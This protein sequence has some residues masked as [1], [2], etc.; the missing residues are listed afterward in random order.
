VARRSRGFTLIEL[1]VVIAIIA[2][3]IGLL[4]PALGKARNAA[5]LAISM[6]NNRQILVGS[7]QYRTA[8]KDRVPMR[9]TNYAN[10][11]IQGG[12]D[13]WHYGGK[14]P[15]TP[16]AT[17]DEPAHSRPLNE[18]LYSDVVFEKPAGYVNTGSGSTWNFNPGSV[19]ANSNDRNI[20][21]DAF[22]SPGD[23]ASYQGK[24]P[25]QAGYGSANYNEIGYDSEGTSYHL[26][27]KWWDQPGMPAGFTQKLNEGVRRIRLASEYDPTG[28]FVW[29]HDQ[30]ADVVANFG[31]LMGEYQELNKS[32]L[33]FL[34]GRC[35]YRLL[36]ARKLYDVI[37]LGGGR[38]AIGKYTFIFVPPGQALPPP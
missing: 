15:K 34:D 22:K 4:L 25:S 28:K 16:W 27:F 23:R 9:G 1:L 11:Q 3:L 13:T 8:D 30:T 31:N 19:P 2:L 37:E 29:I 24:V 32:V 17:F 12:W 5:R 20:Q 6:N 14:C 33:A 7:H 36:Q 21:L 18:Y 35:E 38:R 26:N 10:G